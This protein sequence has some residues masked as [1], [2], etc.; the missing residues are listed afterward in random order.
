MKVSFVENNEID[1][2]KWDSCILNSING[3]PYAYSWY[4]N[5]VSDNWKALVMNNYEAVMPLLEDKLFSLVPYIR[6]DV[7]VPQL[8]IFTTKLLTKEEKQKFF[9][10]LLNKYKWFNIR[11]NKLSGTSFPSIYYQDNNRYE[12]DLINTYQR[13][14]QNYHSSLQEKLDNAEKKKITVVKGLMPNDLLKLVNDRYF[15]VNKS[16]TMSLRIL[17]STTLRYRVGQIYGAYTRQNNICSAVLFLK[18]NKKAIMLV[19]AFTNEAIESN[20]I[21][22]TI[23]YYLKMH[24]E[25]DLTLVFENIGHKRMFIDY[26]AFGSKKMNYQTIR[27]KRG[28]IRF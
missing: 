23:D 5:I 10:I 20:A 3:L 13:I 24:A 4:L 25:N 17:A 9:G 27:H 2:F 6:N 14:V 15:S 22:K 18:S 16:F 11:L 19:T 26:A 21:E 1:L 8:G 7:L 12:L 28:L